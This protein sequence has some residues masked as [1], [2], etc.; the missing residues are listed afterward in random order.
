MNVALSFLLLIGSVADAPTFH[1]D[2]APIV[3][4]R[5]TPCHQ[6]GGGAPFRLKSYRDLQKRS[7]H[8]RLLVERG[9]MPPWLPEE[10]HRFAGS[11]ALTDQEQTTLLRW[12][13]AG[14]PEGDEVSTKREAATAAND[15]WRWGKPDIELESHRPFT[16]P[17]EGLAVVQTWVYPLPKSERRFLRHV[18]FRPSEPRAL[19]GALYLADATGTAIRLDEGSEEPGYR[20]MGHVG[21]NLSGALG[22]WVVGSETEPLPPGYGWPLPEP[23][24]NGPPVVWSVQA[25]LNPMG[26]RVEI[27]TKLALYFAEEP[28]EHP[29]ATVAMTDLELSIPVGARDYLAEDEY[30]CPVDV[31]LVGLVPMAHYLCRTM[32]VTAE[33]P[34]LPADPKPDSEIDTPAAPRTIELL[35][36]D[37]W[38]LNWQ[39]PY[40]LRE[41]LSLPA[42]TRIRMEY[43][44][45]NSPDN[46]RNP[47]IPPRPAM[48]GRAPDGEIAALLLHLAPAKR[49]DYG[50][51]LESHEA[52]FRRRLR[53]RSGR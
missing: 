48:L 18:E 53:E 38:D 24:P 22:G 9:F 10:G 21:L 14:A 27:D 6:P 20:A 17:A 13:D 31:K 35:R 16:V 26:R 33:L 39:E 1:R 7:T 40:R 5:C 45:D 42:G 49:A 32:R 8:I 25:H 44:Y 3:E 4:R 47:H 19:H 52:G 11:R 28:V 43:R 12:I 30:R 23:R 36:I 2:V 34:E 46:P 15:A 29:I 37:D 51:L 41:P 50:L